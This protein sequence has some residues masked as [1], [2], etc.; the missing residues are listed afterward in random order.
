MRRRTPRVDI[1]IP[2]HNRAT[3]LERAI[4]SVLAQSFTDFE[5]YVV[6]DGST[7]HT[8]EVVMPF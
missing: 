2:T 6:D 3:V 5:L 1:I 4:Q 8:R 7:D